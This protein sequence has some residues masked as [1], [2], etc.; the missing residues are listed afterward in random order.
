MSAERYVVIGLGHVRSDWFTEVA[1]WSTSGSIP[2]EFVKCVSVEELRARVGGGRRF[3][4]ALLDGRLPAVDR[5]LLATLADAAI[6]S[7]VAESV[8]T[9]P[10]WSSLGAAST[11]AHGF[12]RAALL[13]ALVTHCQMVGM[14]DEEVTAPGAVAT[15]SAAWQGRLVAVTGRSG[16]GTST[17]AAAL[18]QGLAHDARYAGDVVLADFAHHAHQALLHDAQ[19][20]VPGLQ[21]LVEAHRSGRPTIEQLRCLTFDVPHRGYRLLLGLRRSRD[22]VTIRSRAFDAALDGLRRS[23]R[24]VV[25][26][27]DADVEGEVET[28]SFDLED[29][30]LLARSTLGQADLA[31]VVATPSI[32]G[33]HGLVAQ[34]E[35]LRGHG[36]GDGRI[37][38]VVN[39]APRQSRARAEL[40]RAIAVLTGAADRSD[41]HLGPVYVSE[42]RNVDHLHRDLSRFPGAMVA[43]TADAV[44][45]VLD[46]L[47][48]RDLAAKPVEPVTVVPGSLGHWGDDEEASS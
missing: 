8:G 1:R 45:A 6:P 22:W 44:R 4:A 24:I 10:D 2:V 42:R 23:A 12:D 32:S 28:G 37:L 46:R 38:V 35:D 13:D 14:A 43:P 36:V 40:T 47:P 9:G 3:S 16:S 26:D 34:L 33:I 18:A 30:N 25:A 21:E 39:R 29:R 20:V 7:I 31:V 19:D 48:A 27:T 17:V 41:P 11:L 15:A 5:D